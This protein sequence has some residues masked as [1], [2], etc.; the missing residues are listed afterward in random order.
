MGFPGSVHDARVFRA[1]PLFTSLPNKCGN[2]YILGDSAYPCLR[3]LLTPFKDNGQLSRRQQNYNLLL[4]KNRYV[5]EHCFGLLKQ[6]FRQL[7][8][9]KL[10][11]ISVIVHFIRACAVLHNL[12]VDDEF[13]PYGQN[14]LGH[15]Q[16]L[17]AE[18]QADGDNEDDRNGVAK[19]N[20]VMNT[21]TFIL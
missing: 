12:C 3:H 1:S 6:R 14:I 10:H 5:I 13:I 11:N 7:Y 2:F 15:Y 8:H 16:L 20:E 21:L 19:R 18:Q 9:I 17:N 4:S